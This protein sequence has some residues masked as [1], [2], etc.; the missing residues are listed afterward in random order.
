[1]RGINHVTLVGHAGMEPE[2]RTTAKGEAV[3]R[4]RLATNHGV[5]RDGTWV[6]ETDW[7][8]VELWGR[9]AETA[10][11]FVRRGQLVGIEGG[12][13]VDR[14][15]DKE[16]LRRKKVYVRAVRLHL[17]GRP[18]LTPTAIETPVG[19]TVLAGTP[20]TSDPQPPA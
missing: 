9:Q 18:G 5:R 10:A 7:H 17:M 15:I 19:T 16:G 14:W 1:M 2:V 13:R 12:L 4:L 8:D 11:R 6:Q 3:T 20:P